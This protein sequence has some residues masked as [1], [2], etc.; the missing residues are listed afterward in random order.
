L[1]GT[2]NVAN[3]GTGTTSLTGIVKANGTGAM[4]AATAGTDYLAPNGSAANLTNFPTFNQNT[5]GTATNVSGV[6]AGANGGTGIDNTGK[7]IT[8][9]GNLTTSGAFATTLT[10]TAT[11]DVTLPVTG[12]LSTLAGT[13]TLT[14]KTL[15]SP[16]LTT[17]DIGTPSAAVLTNAT[18]L[19]LST[20]VTG[21]L[22]VSN[23]GT[24]LTNVGTDGQV[25]TTNNAGTLSWTTPVVEVFDELT[26]TNTGDTAFT[27]TATPATSSIVKMYV[28]GVLISKTGYTLSGT[29]LTYVP[30]NNVNYALTAGDRV[31][32]I[33]TH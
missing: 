21:T 15:T 8:L 22:P 14:N 26:I 3:G 16:I 20:G 27:L 24:G 5:T 1:G 2:L 30:A 29:A 28:N 33:Y 6:V 4:T 12:T 13:E 17:P 18:G 32:F 31:Q 9:G 7:T 19:P 25:L 11:T 23:G 10:T